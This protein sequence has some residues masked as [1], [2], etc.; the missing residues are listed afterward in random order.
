MELAMD[1][2]MEPVKELVRVLGMAQEMVLGTELPR[3]LEMGL[4][5]ELKMDELKVPV[6][7]AETELR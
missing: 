6:M 3:D 2:E 7:A 1:L 5:M 4:E